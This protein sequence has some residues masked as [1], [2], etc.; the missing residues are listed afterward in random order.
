[1]DLKLATL[2][3]SVEVKN[4]WSY[5][6]ISS[7]GLQWNYITVTFTPLSENGVI[8]PYAGGSSEM[9]NEIQMQ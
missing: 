9:D 2:P 3:T 8:T 5:T 4:E 6:F 7:H 1:M